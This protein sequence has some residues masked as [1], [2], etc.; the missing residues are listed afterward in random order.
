MWRAEAA[1]RNELASVSIG[2][3]LEDAA[4]QIEEPRKVLSKQWLEKALSE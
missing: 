3:V 4:K 2:Q 1:W